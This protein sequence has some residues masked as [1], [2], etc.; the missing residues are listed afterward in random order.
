MPLQ[1]SDGL[2]EDECVDLRTNQQVGGIKTFIDALISMAGANAITVRP[3]VG[4][5]ESSMRFQRMSDGTTPQRGDSWIIGQGPWGS[6]R[7]F[8]KA[9]WVVATISLD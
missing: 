1:I 7:N 8:V 5:G 4:A 3:L 2:Y 6:A 9:R